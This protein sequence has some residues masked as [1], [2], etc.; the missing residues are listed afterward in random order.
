MKQAI[1]SLTSRSHGGSIPG[2]RQATGQPVRQEVTLD[3]GI[4]E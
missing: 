1:Y 4:P 2:L 3:R